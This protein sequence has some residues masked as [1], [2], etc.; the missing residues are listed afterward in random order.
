MEFAEGG[1]DKGDVFVGFVLDE[2]MKCAV[3][4]L[5]LGLPRTGLPFFRRSR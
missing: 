1:D 5:G 3:S 4:G 2:A